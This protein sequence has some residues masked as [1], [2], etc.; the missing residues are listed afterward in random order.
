MSDDGISRLTPSLLGLVGIFLSAS[1]IK[2]SRA[3]IVS[4]M[5]QTETKIKG[6]IGLTK[7]IADLT[8]KGF[9]IFLPISEQKDFD[10]IAFKDG[11]TYRIQC[12]YSSIGFLQAKK[13]WK[14]ADGKSK[15][16]K[17]PDD[18][19]DF[20]ALYLPDIDRCVYPSID[21]RG[22][23]IASVIPNSSTPFYWWE[24]FLNFTT[25]AKKRNWKEFGI[26]LKP[27]QTQKVK[28]AHK[29]K[30][31]I[32]NR[33]SKKELKRLLETNSMRAVGKMFGVSDNGVR[34]WLK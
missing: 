25:K 28:A 13:D 7:I 3:V 17:Y 21:F 10:L 11:E 12:K 18:A 15:T 1:M 23:R 14:G 24:D 31:K 26:E 8:L 19:F 27:T 32:K 16:R 4:L 20:Y 22:C 9:Q 5:T 33:P 6:D 34:K 30:R 2:N 29:R